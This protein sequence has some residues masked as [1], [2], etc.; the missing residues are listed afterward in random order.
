MFCYLE[1]I[2]TLVIAEAFPE[3]GGVFCCAVSNPYGS[4]NSTA[5]LTVT[6]G[7]SH[8]EPAQQASGG[9]FTFSFYSD[10]IAK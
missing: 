6:A 5:D 2:C 8:T 4:M 10:N 7:E 3:D 1:E 9:T